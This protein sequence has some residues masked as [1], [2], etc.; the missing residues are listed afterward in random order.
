MR[1]ARSKRI[2]VRCSVLARKP[3]LMRLAP[4]QCRQSIIKNPAASAVGTLAVTGAC[5]ATRPG[6]RGPAP[7]AGDQPAPHRYTADSG[8]CR[9]EWRTARFSFA[10]QAA[11]VG[12]GVAFGTAA[13]ATAA[14]RALHALD[15]RP[16][17]GRQER[18]AV[19]AEQILRQRYRVVKH[20]PRRA[21]GGR[22]VDQCHQLCSTR[23]NT[24]SST[25][26]L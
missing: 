4:L 14:A 17:P 23:R 24:L 19:V 22:T 15:L 10:A 2:V 6:C 5:G 12:A 26:E 7:M 21:L 11:P 18:G 9:P 16:A 1:H 20:R 3:V 25:L 13:D 8:S